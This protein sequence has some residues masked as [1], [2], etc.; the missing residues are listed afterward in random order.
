MTHLLALPAPPAWI[1]E[2][3]GT[4]A[5]VCSKCGE[6]EP[7]EDFPIKNKANALRKTWCRACCRAYGREHYQ[8]NRSAYL[9]RAKSRRRRELPR[10]RQIIDEYVR[11][12]PCIDCGESDGMVLDFDHRDRSLKRGIVS[13]LA[14]SCAAGTVRAEMAKCDVRCGNCHRRRTAEQFNW[15]K[16]LGVIIDPT[17]IRPG[18]AGRYLR[19]A[20]PRQDALFSPDPHGLRRCSRCRQLKSLNEFSF[21]DLEKGL[22]N[23][24]CRPC[25]AAYR[26]AHYE[27]NKPDYIQRAMSEM[28]MKR[29]DGLLLLHE[30]LRSRPCADCGETDITVLEFDHRE[31]ATKALDIGAMVGRRSWSMI[32]AE[33]EKCDVR[34]VNCHRRRTARQQGWKVRFAEVRGLYAR[35]GVLAGVL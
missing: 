7:V 5:R 19:P 35:I 9:A 16:L 22:R 21:R 29:E 2:P 11:T 25:H 28:R 3:V 33:I 18:A 23:H 13:R 30:Y 24:Y 31:P 32:S 17:E 15:T 10:I 6:V 20:G 12:H 14:R 4:A 1:D 26:R 8:E 34:C 27:H